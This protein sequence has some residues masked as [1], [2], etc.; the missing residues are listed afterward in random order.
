MDRYILGID[1]GGTGIKGGVV[2]VVKGEL[3][4]DRKRLLTPKP[5]TPESMAATF[6]ELVKMHDW[7][8]PIAAGFPAIVK[9]GVCLTASNIE[10][11]W[12]GRSIEKTFS[13]ACGCPVTAM[14]DADAAG[15]AIMRLGLGKGRKGLVLVLTIG[16]GIGSALFFDGKLIANTEL[17]H[18]EFKGDIAEHYCSNVIREK[19]KMSWEVWGK[20]VNEYLQHLN[21]IFSLDCIIL[22]GGVSKRFEDFKEYL[23]VDVEILPAKL[24]NAAGT[25]GAALYAADLNKEK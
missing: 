21:D 9:N 4:D 15:I 11:S 16:T 7:K 24:K 3:V 5:A 14:N 12:I 13:D 1:V 23:T 6:A 2:D 19:E 17:G 22:G 8:G 18:L 25:I 20:R 10:K